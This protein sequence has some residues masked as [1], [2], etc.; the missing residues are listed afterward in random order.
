ML[1]LAIDT[2]I[3]GFASVEMF[4]T[5]YQ[6]VGLQGANKESYEFNKFF[7]SRRR[8]TADD[9]WLAAPNSEVLYSNAWLDLSARP[10]LLQ[11]PDTNDRYYVLQFLDFFANAFA[12]VGSRTLGN[13]AMNLAIV[14]PH[15]S[16]ELPR[17]AAVVKSP[18]NFAWIFGRIDIQGDHEFDGVHRLQDQFTL[19]SL[20][21][22]GASV[23]T[24][25]SWPPFREGDKLDF[26]AN[27]D[28]VL[29]RN[30]PPKEE[31]ELFSR[32]T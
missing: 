12:Y 13:R 30:C 21:V 11:V 6:L 25:E 28:Q 22:S 26:F 3:F 15:W 23:P 8:A 16:G 5:M 24:T 4:R 31:A 14:G 27:L 1:R 17:T 29:R 19:S 18:T 7:H 2:Y 10:L 32:L 20:V 9:H